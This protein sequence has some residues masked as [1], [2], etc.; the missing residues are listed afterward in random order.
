MLRLCSNS[1]TL[2]SPLRQF[3]VLTMS[4]MVSYERLQSYDFLWTPAKD[5]HFIN[6]QWNN[7]DFIRIRCLYLF[8]KLLRYDHIMFP[9]TEM[10]FPTLRVPSFL[11][12]L[13]C[14]ESHICS[15]NLFS[16]SAENIT[17]NSHPIHGNEVTHAETLQLSFT[18]I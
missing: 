3:S 2:L 6:N 12:I 17:V 11:R 1:R 13:H 16:I 5:Q 7:T 15:N 9:S 18:I 10:R 4:G 14:C 8:F